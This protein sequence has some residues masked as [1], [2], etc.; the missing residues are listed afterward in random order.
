MTPEEAWQAL[1]GG[2][3]RRDRLQLDDAL[4]SLLVPVRLMV[5]ATVD[6]V[7]GKGRKAKTVAQ[8]IAWQGWNPDPD[9]ESAMARLTGAGSFYWPNAIRAWHAARQMLTSDPRVHQIQIETISGREIGRLYRR[10]A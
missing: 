7:K 1:T 5:F 3:V 8:T 10:A 2:L 9:M 4:P 6:T